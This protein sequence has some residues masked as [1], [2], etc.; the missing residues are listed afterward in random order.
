MLTHFSL[1]TGIGGIDIAAEWAGFKPVGQCEF[2]PYPTKILEKCWPDVPR[3]KDVRE[4][5]AESIQS[6]G[7]GEVTLLSGGFPCQPHSLAGKRMASAD[8]RDLWGEF[9]RI[10]CE[11][12][13]KWVLG[14]NVAGLLSSENGQ[15]FGRVLRDLAGMGYSVGWCCI[16][17]FLTGAAFSRARVF[18]IASSN[19]NGLQRNSKRLQKTYQSDYIQSAPSPA[20]N[21]ALS[22]WNRQKTDYDRIRI[23]DGVSDWAHRIKAL[24]NA[25]NPY[26][27][28]PIVKLIAEL[29]KEA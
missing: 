5:T 15:F 28:Y 13:P 10:I 24:G 3:W 23:D 4:V 20:V 12:K 29:Q 17:A 22:L 7:I 9:A 2:A 26:Q 18:L 11:V 27:V 19:S 1:F 14:E 8:E 25:V 21:A 16:P 6:R